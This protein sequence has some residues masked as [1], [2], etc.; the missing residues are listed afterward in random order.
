MTVHYELPT[1]ADFA[2]LAGPHQPGDHHL[3]VDLA[4][5]HRART[6]GGRREERLRRGDRTGQG[7]RCLEPRAHRAPPGTRGDPRRRAALGRPRPLARDLRLARLQRGVRPAEPARRRVACRLAL[8]A[9]PAAAGAEPGPGGVRRAVSANEWT[10][11]HATPTDRAAQM[12]VDPDAAQERRRR[13]QPRGRR[14]RHAPRRRT[15]RPR[16]E[17]GGPPFRRSS[18]STRSASPTRCGRCCRC[19]TP[20]SACRCSSSPRSRR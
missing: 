1:T 18:T 2:A 9:G 16:L 19:T 3:R 17:R 11:W 5:R 15:R 4:G 13:G 6:R 14:G 10:L 8:H 20:T 7:I 12:P